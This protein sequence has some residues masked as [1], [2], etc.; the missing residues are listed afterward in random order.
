MRV[1]AG[2]GRGRKLAARRPSR[3]RRAVRRV[4]GRGL[5]RRRVRVRL[6]GVRVRGERCG[7]AARLPGV[8][9]RRPGRALAPAPPPAG[10]AAPVGL[11]SV[12]VAA[13]AVAGRRRR[14]RRARARPP[15]AAARQHRARDRER[16]AAAHHAG[17][18][19]GRRVRRRVAELRSAARAALTA[20]PPAQPPTA[21]RAAAPTARRALPP[22]RARRRALS[23]SSLA[24]RLWAASV[25]ATRTRRLAALRGVHAVAIAAPRAAAFPPSPPS[26]TAW[27]PLRPALPRAPPRAALRPRLLALRP[28]VRRSALAAQRGGVLRLVVLRVLRRR[29]ARAVRLAGLPGPCQPAVTRATHTSARPAKSV[30]TRAPHPPACCLCQTRN[31]T[32]RH[33]SDVTPAQLSKPL[34]S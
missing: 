30:S 24:R 27:R 26:A 15:S 16:V 21:A 4:G 11:R 1:R 23:L 14:A 28:R 9:P 10:L 12:R 13:A 19:R 5:W 2:R 33:P 6:A 31:I 17:G 18:R 20:V 34:T 22:R 32:M 29:L 7:G 3:G 8:A 25:L